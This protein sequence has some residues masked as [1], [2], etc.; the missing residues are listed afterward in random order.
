M[1]S[2]TERSHQTSQI[3]R[4]KETKTKTLMAAPK[5]QLDQA[6]QRLCTV[7]FRRDILATSLEITY[8]RAR[9]QHADIVR[10]KILR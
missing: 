10:I 9:E 2:V 7:I 4:E 8:F 6:L 3:Q 5:M 1:K